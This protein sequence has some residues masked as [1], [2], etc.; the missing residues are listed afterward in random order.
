[1]PASRQLTAAADFNFENKLELR[2]GLPLGAL[3]RS[4]N[5]CIRPLQNSIDQLRKVNCAILIR[6]YAIA[7][8]A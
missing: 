7:T 8:S 3:R 4:P 5:Q 1:V 2:T 6:I